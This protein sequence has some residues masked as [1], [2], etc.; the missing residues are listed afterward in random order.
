[1]KKEEPVKENPIEKLKK[2]LEKAIADQEFEQAAVLR[3][4]IKE[5]ENNSSKNI[6]E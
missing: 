6:E 4:K 1:M 2:E 3:D 5:I